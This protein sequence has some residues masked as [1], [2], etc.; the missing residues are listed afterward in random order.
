M[1]KK[2]E[3]FFKTLVI[4]TTF[5]FTTSASAAIQV[6]GTRF[7]FEESMQEIE[8]EIKNSEKRASL[9]QVWLEND[10]PE[11]Q[12]SIPFTPIPPLF[13]M[14]KNSEQ[15]VKVIKNKANLAK[16]RETLFYIS[17]LDIPPKDK[18]LTKDDSF[19]EISVQSAFKFFYRPKLKMERAKAEQN[20][21]WRLVTKNKVVFIEA[22]NQSPYF[23]SLDALKFEHK[24][25]SYEAKSKM[26]APFS[27]TSFKLE[28]FKL[29]ATTKGK[30]KFI[31]ID[32]FGGKNKLEAKI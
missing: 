23:I 25:K 11:N 13:K 28:N 3:F 9:V 27:T 14:P 10:T 5:A 1:I 7:V 20:I 12:A 21:H 30:I 18:S 15:T 4:L 22:K 19:I 26:L 6:Y 17:F 2:A 8:I 32:D 24:N 31:S 29:P 16:D